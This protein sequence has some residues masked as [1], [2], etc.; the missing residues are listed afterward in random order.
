MDRLIK[1]IAILILTV[2]VFACDD[3]NTDPSK[4]QFPEEEV[5][6]QEHV[7][8]FLTLNCG[9]IGCH[10]AGA[11]IDMT[12]YFTLISVPG[13]VKPGNPDASQLIQIIEEVQ[14]H[15]IFYYRNITEDQ[16]RGMRQWVI[17]GA[18]NN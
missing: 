2:M 1:I 18:L 11:N 8:P 17:E 16:E 10:D 7:Q 6:Y 15:P 3:L 4:I 12:Q 14:P 9:Y 13:L 5:S